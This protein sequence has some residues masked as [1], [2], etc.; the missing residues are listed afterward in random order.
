LDPEFSPPVGDVYSIDPE[1]LD[2][3]V[4]IR[5]AG[6]SKMLSK[7]ALRQILPFLSQ[8]LITGPIMQEM[9][10]SGITID[11]VEY[12]RMV[13]DAVGTMRSYRLVRPMN[14]NEI[15]ARNQVPAVEQAKLQQLQAEGQTRK[16][17]MGIK[18]QG[19]M[20]REQLKDATKNK[21][22]DED[23]S[24]HVL[25]LMMD[26]KNKPNPMLE[27]QM[28]MRESQQKLQHKQVEHQMD[29]Q[30]KA[31]EHGLDMQQQLHQHNFDLQAMHQRAQMQQQTAMMGAQN[32]LTGGAAKAAATRMQ[33]KKPQP[34]AAPPTTSL[35]GPTR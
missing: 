1:V 33:P 23:S 22:I 17:I 4:K 32:V 20:Q 15:Q 31:R 30:Q 16:D 7:E 11:F 19:A 24:K 18:E 3:P 21:Q 13:E 6:A 27:A 14:Q 9:A 34:Q 8:T 26:A 25:S 29:M 12:A 2:R 35:K 5:I 28:K 10:Q